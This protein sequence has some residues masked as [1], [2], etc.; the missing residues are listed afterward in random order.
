MFCAAATDANRSE[1]QKTRRDL[2]AQRVGEELA[3][4]ATCVEIPRAIPLAPFRI[5]MF[6]MSGSDLKPTPSSRRFG[7][8]MTNALS[9]EI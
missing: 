5:W 6:F 4:G 8:V 9:L 3:A 1:Q 7:S 2:T